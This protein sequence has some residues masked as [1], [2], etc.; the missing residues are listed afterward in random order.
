[1]FKIIFWIFIG[2]MICSTNSCSTMKEVFVD[3]GAKE[4]IIEKIEDIK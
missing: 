4:A 2:Y 3:S 1:M